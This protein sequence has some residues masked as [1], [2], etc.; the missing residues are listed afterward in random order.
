MMSINHRPKPLKLSSLAAAL[1]AL[2]AKTRLCLL[3]II[4]SLVVPSAVFAS[5][6]A[7]AKR[8]ATGTVAGD[9]IVWELLQE[10]KAPERLIAVSSLWGHPS[11]SRFT[12]ETLP[13]SVKARV[14]DSIEAL[15]KLQPDLVI[16]AS[17]NRPEFVR[18]IEQSKIKVLLQQRFRSIEDVLQ[19]ILEIGRAIGA[20]KHA[21]AMVKSL[22]QRLQELQK[23]TLRSKSGEKLRYLNYSQF[24]NFYGK[25]STFDSMITALD[26]INISAEIG[27]KGW[28]RMNDE[29][30]VT[31]KPDIIVISDENREQQIEAMLASSWR[32]LPA[33]QEKRF[34]FISEKNLQSV[35]QHMVDAV[36]ELHAAL[37]K[38]TFVQVKP[39]N[40]SA[41]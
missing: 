10:L 28:S 23:Q 29:L 36:E 2:T 30:L 6:N 17:Y 19:N 22:R 31:L 35:S 25:D 26:G 14:G 33:A 40:S 5:P 37:A 34:V 16:L 20:D 38:L 3:F 7:T 4:L 9:E 21:K 12:E 11:Y 13:P 18:Q 27:L 41:K 39:S 1:F 15:L 8:I 24:G 32:H